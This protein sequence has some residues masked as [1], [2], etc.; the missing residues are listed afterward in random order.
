M[1]TIG[2]KTKMFLSLNNGV[3]FTATRV[4]L[5]VRL[6][7]DICLHSGRDEKMGKLMVAERSS[8]L[9]SLHSSNLEED[10]LPSFIIIPFSNV[11]K[12]PFSLPSASLSTS[13]PRS[14]R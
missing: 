1:W 8:L 4:K 5:I 13:L 10:L 9:N 7:I 6:C 14:S 2:Q 3:V 11:D 12:A